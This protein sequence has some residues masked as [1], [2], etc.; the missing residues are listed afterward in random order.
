MGAL[1]AAYGPLL[2]HLARR[3]QL[4]LP[5]VGAVFVAHFSGGLVG[6]AA[7]MWAVER[8][9]ARLLLGAGVGLMGLGC[10]GVAASPSWPALLAGVFVIGVGFGALDLGLNQVVAH[11]VSASRSALLN[12]LNGAYG[13]GAVAAPVLVSAAGDRSGATYAGAALLAVALLV[14]LATVSGRLRPPAGTAAGGSGWS[15][16]VALFCLAFVLYVGTETGTGGWM[17]T[18]LE[19]AGY[20]S[21]EAAR[22][23]SGFWLA[24]AV[25]RLAVA[26]LTLRVPAPAIV[27]ASMAVAAGALLAALAAPAAPA[28]YVLA[29][30]AIAPVFPTGIVW[31]TRLDGRP[32]ATSWLFP[33]TMVG[34][35]V[36]PAGIGVAIGRLGLPW[37]PPILALVAAGTL[38][39]FSAAALVTARR[40]G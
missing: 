22:L 29:G 8:V 33:A 27:L 5:A 10:A 34:G 35:V 20:P 39:V 6:V 14:P 26:P 40:R 21:A 19:S 4:G 16:L 31:L 15:G 7:A 23:T 36:V 17:A 25:G 32:R 11:S 12:A 18:H 13:I 24:L 37:V 38:A 3:F 9:A 28:A 1:A 30:L 2:E